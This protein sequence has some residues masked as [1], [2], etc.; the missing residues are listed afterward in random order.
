M[1]KKDTLGSTIKFIADIGNFDFD[2][3]NLVSV[4]YSLGDLQNSETRFVSVAEADYNTIQ[5]DWLEK[6]LPN[7]N[8]ATGLRNNRIKRDNLLLTQLLVDNDLNPISEGEENFFNKENVFA[9]YFSGSFK[10]NNKSNLKIGIRI[11]NTQIDGLNRI[12]NEEVNQDYTDLFPSL[13]YG[14]DF[15][16][17]ENISFSLARSIAR[18][19]F[20]DLN[21]F[22][23]KLDDFYY[24]TGNPELKPP[25]IP[26]AQK[27][28]MK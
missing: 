16:N 21:P 25:N 12:N 3:T 5:I 26:I 1:I 17:K 23:L 6:S 19:S 4:D 18:P 15:N 20:R 8:F 2:N 7:F 11:E 10:W 14:Y 24:Q 13:Y 28:H 27:C 22:I 9:G